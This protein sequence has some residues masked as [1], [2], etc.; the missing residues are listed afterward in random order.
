MRDVLR[1]WARYTLGL[2]SPSK[3]LRVPLGIAIAVALL[4]AA[5][6]ETSRRLLSVVGVI[7]GC[8]AL[9]DHRH[10]S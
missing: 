4:T 7:V 1:R 9:Y 2:D 10:R 3:W 6:E 5:T 8:L